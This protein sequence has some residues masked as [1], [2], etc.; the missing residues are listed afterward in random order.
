MA[1]VIKDLEDQFTAICDAAKEVSGL[2]EASRAQ[3]APSPNDHSAMKKLRYSGSESLDLV[4]AEDVV[5][6][7][8]KLAEVAVKVLCHGMSVAVSSLAEF[9]IYSADEH[10]KLVNQPEETSGQRQ[11]VNFNS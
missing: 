11:D 7:P 8:E 9:A 10:S 5:M 3:Y 4:L 1:E 2:L 6:T